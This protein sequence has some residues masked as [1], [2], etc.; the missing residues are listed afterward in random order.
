M[1]EVIEL[2]FKDRDLEELNN[3]ERRKLEKDN[4]MFDELKEAT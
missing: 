2:E 1:K 4:S 3:E